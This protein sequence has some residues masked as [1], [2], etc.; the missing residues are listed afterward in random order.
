MT[1]IIATIFTVQ[2]EE[3]FDFIGIH[4]PLPIPIIPKEAVKI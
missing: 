3:T 4:Q 2:L 1:R